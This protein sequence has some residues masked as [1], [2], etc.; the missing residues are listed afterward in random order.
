[1]KREVDGRRLE[2]MTVDV[3]TLHAPILVRRFEE[4]ENAK[5]DIII[6]PDTPKE[7][8]EKDE[9]LDAQVEGAQVGPLDATAGHGILLGIQVD[10]EGYLIIR[11][12]E[13]LATLTGIAN[14]AGN[15]RVL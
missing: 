12:E 3:T 4:K 14:A 7:K 2:K 6:V 11:E 13:H 5:G 10:D 8:P 9:V 1:L 15:K